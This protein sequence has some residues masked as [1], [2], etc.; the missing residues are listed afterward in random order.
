LSLADLPGELVT[1]TRDELIARYK[2]DYR[3]RNP[4]ADV[5]SGQPDLDAKLAADLVLPV[6]HDA[7]LIAGGINEDAAT[8]DRLDLVGERVG[9]RRGAAAGASGYVAVT[10][11]AGGG[12]INEFDE[13]E[14]P[15]TKKKYESAETRTRNNGEHIRVR[16]KS[17]GPE[18]DVAP[19]TILRWTSPRPGIGQNATVVEQTDGIGLTGGAEAEGD[20]RYLDGIRDLKQN[21]SG[22]DNDAE[23]RD[24]IRKTPDIPIEQVFTYPAAYAGGTSAFTFTVLAPRLGASRLATDAQVMAASGWMESQMPGDNSYFPLVA[25]SQ[26]LVLAFAVTWVSGG[27]ADAI[28]WPSAYSSTV[29]VSAATGPLAF[30]VSGGSTAPV[31]GQTIAVWDN[32]R[33]QFQRKRIATVSGSGPW[34]LT[35]TTQNGASDS[36]YQPSV[37][38]RV[39]PW[40][41]NLAAVPAP[42]LKYLTTLGP[43]EMF[44]PADIPNEEGRRR[45]RE[46]RAPKAWPSATS[47][48]L[49]GDL[50]D[51]PEVGNVV[52]KAGVGVA[53]AIGYPP[54]MLQLSD[55]SIFPT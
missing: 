21:P 55:L 47:S 46:P 42:V 41:D 37:G 5:V 50:G 54:K 36:S 22:G 8:G 10:A 4:E 2:R 52:A 7:K 45:I 16:A 12:T 19:G 39:S 13:L 20:P 1:F 29:V 6:Y 30:T 15:Q 33:G 26:S 43:G 38:Q 44:N 11:A 14:N 24:V 35:F 25:V 48:R 40:S 31:V 51:I 23:L 17:K 53:A 9:R 27:W 18:T 32:G 49:T 28:P 3:L 34:S